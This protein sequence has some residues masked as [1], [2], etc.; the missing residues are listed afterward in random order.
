MV[1][2]LIWVYCGKKYEFSNLI[3]RIKICIFCVFIFKVKWYDMDALTS[4]E[5]LKI[6]NEKF[7]RNYESIAQLQM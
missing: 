2:K 7:K 4:D 3:L 6:I 5:A 1:I